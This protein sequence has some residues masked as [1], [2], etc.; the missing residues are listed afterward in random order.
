[1]NPRPTVGMN[2]NLSWR[3]GAPW[4]RPRFTSPEVDQLI[5]KASAEANVTARKEM[6]GRIQ[7]LIYESA[8]MTIPSFISYVDG[9]SNKVNGLSALPIG[10]LSGYDFA[11]SAWLSE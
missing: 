1:M 9:L 5:D 6:Y 3:S 7:T 4:N 8:A 2:L 11:N 10:S